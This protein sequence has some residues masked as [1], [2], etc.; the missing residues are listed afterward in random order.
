MGGE[1]LVW[2][3]K[4]NFHRFHDFRNFHGIDLVK[5]RHCKVC[6]ERH[7]TVLH[8]VSY[9]EL[10]IATITVKKGETKYNKLQST[11]DIISICIALVQSRQWESGKVLQIY[12]VLDSYSHKAFIL[13]QLKKP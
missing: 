9:R 12:A 2:E 1:Y 10:P 13:R 7:P 3:G 8:G 6:K 11:L 5:I 4:E